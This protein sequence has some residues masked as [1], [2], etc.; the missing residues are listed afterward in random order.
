ML[1]SEEVLKRVG[2]NF[3]DNSSGNIIV[4]AN[5]FL[6]LS[7]FFLVEVVLIAVLDVDSA[8]EVEEAFVLDFLGNDSL[9][10]RLFVFLS[11]LDSLFGQVFALLPVDV[12]ADGFNWLVLVLDS[13]SLLKNFVAEVV[14]GLIES[15]S[16][17]K[18]LI[19]DLGVLNLE[20]MLKDLLIFV[21]DFGV[22]HSTV[23]QAIEPVSRNGVGGETLVSLGSLFIIQ[24]VVDVLKFVFNWGSF[25]ID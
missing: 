14:I 8:E 25:A 11:L 1:D 12:S 9:L 20:Q 19:V 5:S 3:I 13:D 21:L 2:D 16:K 4:N 24:E 22:D 7:L 10:S 18:G 17:F 23:F 6:L 15:E